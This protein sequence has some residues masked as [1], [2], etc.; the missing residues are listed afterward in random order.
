MR[1]YAC[2]LGAWCVPTSSIGIA[3]HVSVEARHMRRYVWCLNL[4][5]DWHTN[6]RGTLSQ[7]SGSHTSCQDS[8]R[9][10]SCLD[11]GRQA[12]FDSH[13][14]MTKCDSQYLKTKC[15]SQYVQ[16]KCDSQYSRRVAGISV[17]VWT[18][19]LKTVG[20]IGVGV[21]LSLVLGLFS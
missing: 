21:A 9:H 7:D 10:T 2:R 3:T 13:T 20:P 1:W 5:V 6:T 11:I 8:G 19:Q 17:W 4:Q 12:H 15:D 14:D 18:C 16:T